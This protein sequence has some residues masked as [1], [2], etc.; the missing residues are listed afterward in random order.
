MLV[1]LVGLGS[2][3]TASAPLSGRRSARNPLTQTPTPHHDGESATS[4]PTYFADI[5]PILRANCE[6]CHQEGGIGFSYFDIDDTDLISDP[7]IAEDLAWYAGTRY[8]PPWP[9]SDASLPMQHERTLTDDE[10]ALI[11]RWALIGGP[12]G[13]P[14][15]RVEMPEPNTIPVIRHDVVLTMAEP[16]VPTG[17]ILDDYRCFLLDPGFD[18][19]M[20]VTGTDFFP[21]NTEIAHH[22]L[23][24]IADEASIPEALEKSAEDDSPGWECFAGT[25]LNQAEGDITRQVQPGETHGRLEPLR[26]WT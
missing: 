1:T 7:L 9:P 25:G 5:E 6:A 26:M 2:L 15:A 11:E 10:I 16:Y 20:L 17:E 13:D 18:V 21:G 19:D 24:F 22:A 23:F 8:M 14:S 3:A 12:M 4:D